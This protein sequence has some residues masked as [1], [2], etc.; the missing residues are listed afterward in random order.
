MSED[1]IKYS[2]GAW[3]VFFMKLCK[4]YK[5]SIENNTVHY[6]KKSEINLQNEKIKY[7]K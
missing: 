4:K 2:V 6:R 3:R 1:V 7:K 5:K